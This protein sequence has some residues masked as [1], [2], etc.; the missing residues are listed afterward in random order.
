MNSSIANGTARMRKPRQ[1]VPASAMP[2]KPT[3]KPYWLKARMALSWP[4]APSSS[5]RP[6]TAMPHH[7]PFSSCRR[8]RSL[9]C[10]IRNAEMRGTNQP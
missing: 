6:T 9:R 3:T 10:Q 2:T 4:T 5:A 7:E 8:R 1:P